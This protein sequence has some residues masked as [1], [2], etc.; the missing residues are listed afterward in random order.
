MTRRIFTLL[1]SLA[2]TISVI[3]AQCPRDEIWYT[4]TDGKIVNIS[5]ATFSKVKS[6]TYSNGK[7]VI[8]FTHELYVIGE[9]YIMG[10]DTTE[11]IL[12]DLENLETIT[13]PDNVGFCISASMMF[14]PNPFKGCPNLKH[15]DWELAS[16]DGKY[17]I[18][19]ETCSLVTVAPAGLKSLTI[20]D[21]VERIGDDAFDCC[22]DLISIKIPSSVEGVSNDDFKD[23]INLQEFSG[24]FASSDGRCLIRGDKLIKFA[25][26]GLTSYT[27]PDNVTTI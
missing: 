6:N 19:D 10:D 14:P 4:T 3:Y 27:V 24:K 25:P 11:I 7:G 2:A 9:Y 16:E 26:A 12:T 1:V 20:P 17:V 15:I 21:G 13:I 8:K 22:K 5:S 23:C 18:D